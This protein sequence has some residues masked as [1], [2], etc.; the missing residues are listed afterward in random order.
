M[1]R[2][3]LGLSLLLAA[4]APREQIYAA[5][6]KETPRLREFPADFSPPVS[7]ESGERVHGFGGGGGGLHRTPVIFVHGNS[8]NANF[9]LS[10]REYFRQAGYSDDELWAIGYGWNSVRA[11]DNHALSV[12]TLA[13]FVDEVQRYLSQKSGRRV[14]QVDIVAHS[15]GVTLVREWM[16]QANAWHRVRNF[17][18]VAGAN[19]GT[20]TSRPDSR[21]QNRIVSF[22]L[23]PGSPWLHQLNRDGETPGA[24]RYLMLYDG[25]GW[26]D[27]F[28]PSPYAHSPALQ[29]ATNLAFNTSHG[30]YFDHLELPRVPET[31]EAMI[32]FLRQA[33][34]PQ[35]D[36]QPPSV[37]RVGHELRPSPSQAVLHC[38]A[39]GRYPDADTVARPNVRLSAAMAPLTCYARDARTALSSPMARYVV[40]AEAQAEGRELTVTATP[41]GGVFEQPQLVRLDVSEPDAF[42]VYTTH[43]GAP[44]SGSPLYRE[45]VYVPGPLVLTAMAIAPDGRRSKPLRLRYDISLEY[46][47]ARH[48]LQ[49]QFDD[50]VPADYAGQRTK[51]N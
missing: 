44:D 48:A 16:R 23:H 33:P 4:C 12:P 28:F 8:V 2:F 40:S 20:W 10:A 29:G 30:T 14:E 13:A 47:Q 5:L 27:V 3:L 17:V 15:L 37:V 42:I 24:T 1:K 38:A 31:M 11:L 9:W 6:G 45:P 18:G 34:E 36:A 35:P 39:Q 49:R 43:G 7:N 26:H 46:L 41:A 22:E 21:G 32:E 51:G 50:T 25:S 19:H